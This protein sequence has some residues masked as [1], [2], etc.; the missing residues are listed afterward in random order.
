MGGV[1][2]T[3]HSPSA[4]SATSDL[5]IHCEGK[6]PRKV[7]A[8]LS[9][10]N[11]T[12]P[13]VLH[14]VESETQARTRTSRL[15]LGLVSC[16]RTTSTSKMELSGVIF[17]NKRSHWRYV[18]SH[19]KS[20][21]TSSRQ[22]NGSVWTVLNPGALLVRRGIHVISACQPLKEASVHSCVSVANDWE[23]KTVSCRRS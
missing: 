11:A 17:A 15:V 5:I 22:S 7:A 20:H 9:A 3:A 1:V 2:S 10:R 8:T 14:V 4:L 21:A 23:L 6:L 18:V 19:Q 13:F 16:A 12:S